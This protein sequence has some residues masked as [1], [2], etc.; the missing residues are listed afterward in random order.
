MKLT[1]E[2]E[3]RLAGN[4]EACG[5]LVTKLDELA[6]ECIERTHRLLLDEAGPDK[7]AVNTGR[8][9]AIQELKDWLDTLQ[10][11]NT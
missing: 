5:L 3:D 10:K 8:Y 2:Q 11:R 9:K 7:H 4:K 1:V 6:G